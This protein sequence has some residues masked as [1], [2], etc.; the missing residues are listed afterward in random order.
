MP[1][2]IV[3][4]LESALSVFGV[5]SMY[6]QPRYE[7][8]ERI[9]AV[10]IRAYVARLAAETTVAASHEEAGRS[11]AF[12]ILAGYIFGG[13]VERAD[14]SMATPLATGAGRVTANEIAMTTPVATSGRPVSTTMRFFLPRKIRRDDVP[15]PTDARVK[16]VELPEETIAA[17]SSR[18]AARRRC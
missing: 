16:I 18:V 1:N 6:E 9:G 2:Y 10:E 5:R 17:L 4:A 13:N 7:V 14:F 3:L 11:Q 12:R 8:V 15:L